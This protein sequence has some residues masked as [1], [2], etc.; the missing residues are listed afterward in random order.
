MH[1]N[2]L[3][4]KGHVAQERRNC[5]EIHSAGNCGLVSVAVAL[6]PLLQRIARMYQRF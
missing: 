5:A 3:D 2:V 6:V 4:I 1:S